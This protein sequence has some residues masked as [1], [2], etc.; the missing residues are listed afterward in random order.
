MDRID[1]ELVRLLCENARYTLKELSERVFL[2]PPAVA[3][4]IERLNKMGIIRGYTA[5]LDNSKLGRGIM[6]Y[7]SIKIPPERKQAFF[8]RVPLIENV[9]EC[10]YITGNYSVILKAVFKTTE[11]LDVLVT[12]LQEFGHTQ[13]QIVFCSPVPHREIPVL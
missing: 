5:L 12:S 8:D 3:S 2:S 6:A 1:T 11:E 10:N 7:I 13:T 9:I 4:R